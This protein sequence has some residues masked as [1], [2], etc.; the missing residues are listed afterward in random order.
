MCRYGDTKAASRNIAFKAAEM[1]ETT[2]GS[3][4]AFL[5]RD[6]RG[7][8]SSSEHE[9]LEILRTCTF[10]IMTSRRIDLSYYFGNY[11]IQ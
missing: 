9:S 4:S 3:Q 6:V 5:V 8:G 2:L 1:S 7:E 11:G 10:L